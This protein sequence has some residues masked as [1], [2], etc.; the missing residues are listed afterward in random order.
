MARRP[1]GP[2]RPK[3][4]GRLRHARVFRSA[5]SLARRTEQEK[6]RERRLVVTRPREAC[7]RWGIFALIT[8]GGAVCLYNFAF[9]AWAADFPTDPSRERFI[10]WSESYGVLF[11]ICLVLMFLVLLLN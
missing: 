6:R 5:Q 4:N 7:V 8:L 9:F 1:R 10:R 11:A 2:H 3:T